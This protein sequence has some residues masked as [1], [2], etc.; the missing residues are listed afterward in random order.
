MIDESAIQAAFDRLSQTAEAAKARAT[1]VYLEEF[2]GHLI[3]LI[4]KE[5]DGVPA[6]TRKE[7][8][9]ADP[10]YAEHLKALHKAVHDDEWWRNERALSIALIEAWRTY[11]A[12]SRGRDKIG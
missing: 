3:G 4:M 10:R 5:L 6:T 7:T 9:R 8:A 2:G 11:E 12:S 1:R